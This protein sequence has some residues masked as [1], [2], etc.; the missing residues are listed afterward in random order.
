MDF[1]DVQPPT[2]NGTFDPQAAFADAVAR[3][4][5]IAAK[6]NQPGSGDAQSQ[7]IKRP[8]ENDPY[9]TGGSNDGEAEYMVQAGSKHVDSSIGA[10]LRAMAD[11]GGMDFRSAHAAQAAQ[12]AQEAAARINQQLGVGPASSLSPQPKP[13]HSGLGFVTTEEYS[14]P[15][16]MVGLV[17]GKGGEQITRLQTETDCKVQIAP[18]SGGLDERPCTLTGSVQAIMAAKNAIQKII[19]KGKSASVSLDRSSIPDGQKVAEI[20]VPGNKVGLVIGKG[21]ETI[22]QLQ[23][24]ACV[25]M[26]M[27]QDSNI[28]SMHDKP[29]RITGDPQMVDHAREMVMGL[30]NSDQ[31]SGGGGGGGSNDYGMNDRGPR[32]G[33]FEMTVPR[34]L[35]G[36]V[37]GKGGDMIKKIQAE[38]NAKVQFKPDD[39]QS[40]ERICSIMGSPDKIQLA[41]DMIQELVNSANDFQFQGGP[42]MG[43]GMGR[44]RGRGRGGPFMGGPG[45]PSGPGRGMGRGGP[46]GG[47]PN[48]PEETNYPVPADKCGLVIGKGGE[49]IKEINRLSGGHVELQRA[50]PPN[51]NQ[52]I[53]TVRG[54]PQQIQHAIQLI[55][56][57]AGL[58]PNDPAGPGGPPGG[59]GGPGPQGPGGG[60]YDQYGQPQ[61]P[62]SPQSYGGQGGWQQNQYQPYQQYQGQQG[63]PSDPSK[64]V[65]ENAAAWAAYY[66]QYYNQYGQQYGQYGQ[67]QQQQAPQQPQQQPQ[68]AQQ[69]PQQQQQQQH[70]YPSPAINPQTGQPDYSAAWVEYYRQQ[71]M[72][73]QASMILQQA[74]QGGAQQGQLPQQ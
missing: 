45:G 53:F 28:P 58:S 54:S 66:S 48:F 44:G 42:G 49:T 43:R 36:V 56:E 4:R 38:T 64:Q 65:A 41:A 34:H 37:I 52:K 8:F 62:P 33:G 46:F 18:D 74:N 70:S 71:G 63:G 68:Q 2:N 27:I 59:P 1:S 39:G 57:K 51:P 31:T 35:V 24:R 20:L 72:H 15:D 16:R 25:K 6:I 5:Q 19:D 67:N 12:V 26:V 10:Q 30:I 23:E 22:K 14:I 11:G 61:Q 55:C 60:G 47:G 69:A 3:A 9:N 17:I 29:L 50:P 21:G 7:G 13:N 40:S 73:M 32:G